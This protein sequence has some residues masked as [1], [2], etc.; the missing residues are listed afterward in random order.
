[1]TMSKELKVIADLICGLYFGALAQKNRHLTSSRFI[2]T[3]PDLSVLDEGVSN[4]NQIRRGC[5]FAST[6]PLVAATR[7]EIS[8]R[9]FRGLKGKN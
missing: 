8:N 9:K 5:C 4:P 6:L 2:G 1:M 7:L 3:C